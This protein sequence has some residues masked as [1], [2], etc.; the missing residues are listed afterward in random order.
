MK[1]S[2]RSIKLLAEAWINIGEMNKAEQAFQKY[3]EYIE[4][5]QEGPDHRG[6]GEMY[7]SF[8]F[9]YC[10][11]GDPRRAKAYLDM[12]IYDDRLE[13]SNACYDRI[14]DSYIKKGDKNC[15]KQAQ[16]VFKTMER[17]RQAGALAP[18]ERVYTSFIR[19]LT[20]SKV[21][22]LHT[23]VDL[24]LQRMNKLFDDGHDD[25]KPSVF[26]YNVALNA[27]SECLDIDGVSNSDAFQ[28]SVR[29]FT[30]LRKETDPDHVTFGNLLRCS[31]LLSESGMDEMEKKDKFVKAT[32]Q[33][34]CDRGLVNSLVLRDLKNAATDATWAHLT[35]IPLDV[36][37]EGESIIDFIPSKWSRNVKRRQ[38][39]KEFEMP[40]NKFNVSR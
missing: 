15:A 22:D 3:E 34:A 36:T 38:S 30:E 13:P 35:K 17:R 32:F 28:T 29:I 19:A 33:L 40:R 18:S 24:I 14:I 23:K 2:L 20:K 9:G 21:P 1:P 12:M 6:L 16:E 10:K 5:E 39:E 37:V 8:L 11:N 27:C 25:V 31:N 4:E 7:E 26:T